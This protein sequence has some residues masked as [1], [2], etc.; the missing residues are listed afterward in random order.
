MDGVSSM[1]KWLSAN[2]YH[3]FYTFVYLSM[4]VFFLERPVPMPIVKKSKIC[5]PRTVMCS[6]EAGIQEMY[7]LDRKIITEA[8]L[9]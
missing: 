2:I 5:S 7:F 9:E 8:S 3:T 1:W 4:C 6:G